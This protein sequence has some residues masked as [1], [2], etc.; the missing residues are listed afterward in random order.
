MTF[1]PSTLS[2]T[3]GDC[4]CAGASGGVLVERDPS[5]ARLSGGKQCAVCAAGLYYSAASPNMCVECP[6][7]YGTGVGSVPRVL[8][9]YSA[10]AAACVCPPA[11]SLPA[12]VTC[13]EDAAYL[14]A[15]LSVPIDP[16]AY[17]ITY[18]DITGTGTTLTVA[19]SAPFVSLLVPSA[20]A[21]LRSGNRTA[22]NAVANLCVLQMYSP[23]AAAC[24]LYSALLTLRQ[25]TGTGLVGR[26]YH[27]TEI[28]PSVGWVDSMPWLYY[29]TSTNY[30]A[31]DDTTL[32]VSLN[33]KVGVVLSAT[34]LNGTWLGFHVVDNADLQICGARL[35]DASAW[36]LPNTD[37]ANS[38][39]LSASQLVS[40]FGSSPV[41]YDVYLQDAPGRLYPIPIVNANY[42]NAA[43]S[44]TNSGSEGADAAGVQVDLFRSE[45]RRVGKE[46]TSWCRSRWSP[47]H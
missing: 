37:Y 45:E 10:S 17:S 2:G 47:Y 42:R 8:K 25:G 31:R 5:G 30:A 15:Q 21:C 32:V 19:N 11:A 44:L 14:T 22:C 36:L 39:T 24:K 43:G 1:A 20:V 9:Q 38:C 27:P 7:V 16:S 23:A 34:S 26:Q 12:G 13:S 33:G 46:C 35:T 3:T 4:T 28:N 41:F 6:V 18:Y 40:M 29:D